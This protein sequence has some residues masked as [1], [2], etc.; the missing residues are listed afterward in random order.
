MN[1]GSPNLD[2]G[3]AFE[4]NERGRGRLGAAASSAIRNLSPTR[5]AVTSSSSSSS[6][7]ALSPA[8]YAKMLLH[9]A[10]RNLAVDRLRT[11]RVLLSSESPSWL[12]DFLFTHRGYEGMLKRI[13]ELIEMEWRE[14]IHDDKALHELLRGL[15]ALGAT[16]K[17]L[18]ALSSLIFRPYLP[19]LPPSGVPSTFNLP[20]TAPA[21]FIGKE[22][23][24][25]ELPIGWELHPP[26]G[27][28]TG[29]LLS[30]K[31]PGE[32]KTRRLLIDMLGLL[33]SIKLPT[34][35]A[36]ADFFAELRDKREVSAFYSAFS[37]SA[38]VTASPLHLLLLLLHNPVQARSLSLLPFISM[39]HQ[40]RPFKTYLNELLS[41]ARDYFWVFCHSGSRFWDWH[42]MGEAGRREKSGPSV[43]GGMTDGVEWEAM[44]YLTANI[45]LINRIAALMPSSSGAAHHFHAALF[46][47]GMERLLQLLRKASQRFYPAA[48]LAIAHYLYLARR[49]GFNMPSS[50]DMRCEG[51][52]TLRLDCGLPAIPART[53]ASIET[54]AEHPH[55]RQRSPTQLDPAVRSASPVKSPDHPW[56]SSRPSQSPQ[57]VEM[58][59]WRGGEPLPLPSMPQGIASVPGDMVTGQWLNRTSSATDDLAAATA[60]LASSASGESWFNSP[61]ANRTLGEEQEQRPRQLEGRR[62]Q[63]L[64]PKRTQRDP[65]QATN[66]NYAT[67]MAPRQ[68]A[69]TS[70]APNFQQGIDAGPLRA[71][72][73][74]ANCPSSFMGATSLPGKHD[75]IRQDAHGASV[76]KLG[77]GPHPGLVAVG[78][79][80]DRIKLW[81]GRAA[82][83]SSGSGRG[84]VVHGRS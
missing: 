54:S 36:D 13:G 68:G 43:P 52:L 72:A 57:K 56:A 16:E 51:G 11:L 71:N 24:P 49:S 32:L 15:V 28:L 20:E 79:A 58:D 41:V 10:S 73:G 39:S 22:D 29:L 2:A 60:F 70:V 25:P 23:T 62:S 45:S 21:A 48:H 27:P 35:L 30:E 53:V 66:E 63:S 44:S 64:S 5:Q 55:E 19:Q 7:A 61:V 34:G 78:T 40:P 8:H 9:T 17:G 6:S 67:E 59:N 37:D 38:P 80:K 82:V 3:V 47:S 46:D 69:A 83:S 65:H 76:N 42:G 26:F 1:A 84:F 18:V 4:R 75:A 77:S 74:S 31:K 14:D 81:E 12:G 50:I 33:L